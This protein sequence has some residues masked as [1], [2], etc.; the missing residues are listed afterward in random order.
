MAMD[1][2][3]GRERRTELTL[4]DLEKTSHATKRTMM[5]IRKYRPEV[6]LPLT[7]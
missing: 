7:L 4:P 1:I 5:G 6:S 3:E 2:S